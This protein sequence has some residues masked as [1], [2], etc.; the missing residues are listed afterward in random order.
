[1]VPRSSIDNDSLS[2]REQ[3]R[4]SAWSQRFNMKSRALFMAPMTT[5]SSNPDLTVS[6]DELRYYKRRAANVDYVITG[7][8]FA[9][10]RQ[11]GFTRQFY[12]GSDDYVAS[13]ITLVEAI[14]GGGAK[15]ILQVHSPG[16]MVSA[17]LQTDPTIE[18]VSA[19]AV[20]PDRAGYRTPRALTVPE[21]KTITHSYYDV[22]VRAIQ[23]GFDGIE[24]HGANTYLPQQFVSPL[25]N[26]RT[27]EYARDGLLFIRELVDA[28]LKARGDARRT[29][30]IVG[31]RF[32]PEE[33]EEGGLR[34]EHTFGLLDALCS[35]PIDYVHA[36]LERYDRT[37]YF[38]DTVIVDALRNCIRQRKPLIGVG[39]IKTREDIARAFSL[40]FDHLAMGTILLLNPDWRTTTRLNMEISEA[41]LPPDIPPR[42][43]DMLLKMFV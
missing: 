19:S 37:S 26:H 20:R 31:Y 6:A 18:V 22:T 16:R 15:A 7:C 8:T 9:L 10:R 4:A 14:H 1:M 25:T 29:D 23:A 12:A 35:W 21:I 3:L 42:M 40:G 38:N 27:D 36:S 11:Q 41:S 28:V 5:W 39:K 32:S 24:I 13:L 33:K 17:E 30:F 43:R 34:L 2:K